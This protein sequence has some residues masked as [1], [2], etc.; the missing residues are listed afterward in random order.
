MTIQPRAEQTLSLR[1]FVSLC[2][3]I[4]FTQSHKAT[5]KRIESR[6]AGGTR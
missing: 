5:K 1:V 3:Q 6:F 4:F 2:E